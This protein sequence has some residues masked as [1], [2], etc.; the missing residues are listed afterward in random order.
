MEPQLGDNIGRVRDA[1]TFLNACQ[2]PKN[3]TDWATVFKA[4]QMKLD[5][6][7]VGGNY[8]G[9]WLLRI[10]MIVEMRAQ[11]IHRL[12]AEPNTPLMEFGNLFP[13]QCEWATFMVSIRLKIVDCIL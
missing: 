6:P 8:V 2:A 12:L 9:P 7:G 13:D 3:L 4:G 5:F 11:G 10:R 1:G